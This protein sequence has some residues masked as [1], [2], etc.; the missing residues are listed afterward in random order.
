MK[1]R[2]FGIAIAVMC[3]WLPAATAHAASITFSNETFSGGSG[4]G[5]VLGVLGLPAFRI[6]FDLPP[7]DKATRIE[8]REAWTR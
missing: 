2:V 7:A 3:G 1:H 5:N 8:R 4:W 6:G